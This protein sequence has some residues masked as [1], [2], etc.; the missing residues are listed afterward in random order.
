MKP[1]VQ[2]IPS[3]IPAVPQQPA[4]TAV[5]PMSIDNVSANGNKSFSEDELMKLKKINFKKKVTGEILFQIKFEEHKYFESKL[6]ITIISNVF[7]F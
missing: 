7:T 6:V 3:V 2:P 5:V 1:E 4:P